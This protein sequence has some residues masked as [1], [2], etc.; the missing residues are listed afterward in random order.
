[1]LGFSHETAFDE[2][3]NDSSEVI[4]CADSPVIEDRRCHQSEFIEGQ[5]A[6]AI[7]QFR[8]G[9]VS[10]GFVQF[11]GLYLPTNDQTFVPSEL[12]AGEAVVTTA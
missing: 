5:F 2:I 6:N 8:T 9:N 10:A 3:K 4:G 1:M 12:L 7:Q 11:P